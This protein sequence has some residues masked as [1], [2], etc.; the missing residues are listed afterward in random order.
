VE[1][2]LKK[3]MNVVDSK[4]PTLYFKGKKTISGKAFNYNVPEFEVTGEFLNK[5]DIEKYIESIELFNK[6]KEDLKKN[7][8]TKKEEVKKEEV[9]SE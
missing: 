8:S 5:V 7:I 2:N 1:T 4:Y 6:Y 9:K 3:A